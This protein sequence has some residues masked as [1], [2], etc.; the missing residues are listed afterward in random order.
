[1]NSHGTYDT[2]KQ[3]AKAHD[4]AAIELGRPLSTL[5]FPKKVPPEY[6]PTNNGQQ[7]NNTTGYRGVSTRVRGSKT[8]YGYQVKIMIKGKNVFLGHFNTRKQAA[9]AYDHA[10]H[11]H[12]L[13]TSW[14]NFPTMKHNLNKEPERKKQK[15]RSSTGFTGVRVLS[16]GRYQ[17]TL[18]R[19]SLGTFDTDKEAASAYD[20]AVLK[21]VNAKKKKQKVQKVQKVKEKKEKEKK[22][23][24]DMMTTTLSKLPLSSSSSS[25]FASIPL[26]APVFFERSEFL[27]SLVN[28]NTNTSSSSS[29]SSSS[30]CSSEVNKKTRV[31]GL[32]ELVGRTHFH[33]EMINFQ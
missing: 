2:P 26:P 18:N 23:K 1:M 8:K 4:A 30:T 7:S 24:K 31:K 12:G 22:E 28:T 15:V 19:R 6:I 3:A 21:H 27:D 10:V 16:S 29:S 17:A 5:N 33:D 9:I 14:L 25:S 13:P 32:M 11:K 20:R